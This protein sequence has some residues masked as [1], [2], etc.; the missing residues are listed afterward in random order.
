M[1][2]GEVISQRLRE[3]AEVNWLIILVLTDSLAT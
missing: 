1:H 3:V 2:K